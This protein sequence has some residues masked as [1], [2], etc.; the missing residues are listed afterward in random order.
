MTQDEL[1]RALEEALNVEPPAGYAARVRA[2]VAAEQGASAGRY[3]WWPLGAL[4]AAA[5]VLVAGGL[6]LERE[7]SAVPVATLTS[8]D[9]KIP[10]ESANGRTPA[11][12]QQAT[13]NER[14]T[15][16]GRRATGPTEATVARRWH[17]G[18][19]DT[20]EA[21]RTA[22]ALPAVIVSPDDA[23]GLRLFV[24]L[25]GTNVPAPAMDGGDREVPLQIGRIDVAPIEVDPL[26]EL[27]PLMLGELQ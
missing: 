20:A 5:L 10:T 2:R 9:D 12:A 18:T 27:I 25:A 7:D 22:S 16:D 13:G 23:A 1:D 6:I 26:A 8:R 11:P 4:A 19:A 14:A 15:G 21:P 3:G 17:A 24:T